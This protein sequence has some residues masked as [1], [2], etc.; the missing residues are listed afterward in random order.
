MENDQRIITKEK[1]ND[2][3]KEINPEAAAPGRLL[4][5]LEESLKVNKETLESVK[6]LK[7]YYFWKTIFSFIKIT[8]LVIIIVLGFLSLK[9]I[10]SYLETYI[11]D[12][13]LYSDQLDSVNSQV[14][15][16]KGIVN[17]K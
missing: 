10:V 15:N 13:K 11:N 5:I 3:K 8:I 14:N 12:L 2:D 6:F 9:P 4:E 17:K 7:N 16:F 1:E